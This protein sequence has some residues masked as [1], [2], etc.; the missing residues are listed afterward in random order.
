[1]GEGSTRGDKFSGDGHGMIMRLGPLWAQVGTLHRY[2][3]IRSVYERSWRSNVYGCECG[4]QS[5]IGAPAQSDP[6]QTGRMV[7]LA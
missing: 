7:E 2:G 5:S 1:M 4:E 3:I 6:Q